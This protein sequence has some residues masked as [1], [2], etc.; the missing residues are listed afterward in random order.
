MSRGPSHGSF[1]WSHLALPLG[2]KIRNVGLDDWPKN[3]GVYNL[4]PP[5]MSD[6]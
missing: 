4:F 2:D 5:S 1:A 6:I 3:D